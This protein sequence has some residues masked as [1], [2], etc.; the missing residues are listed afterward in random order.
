MQTHKYRFDKR[1]KNLCTTNFLQHSDHKK[2]LLPVIKLMTEEKTNHIA[3]LYKLSFI[4]KLP[5]PRDGV[6]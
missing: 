1:I 6:M 2:S 3:L 5:T 4:K